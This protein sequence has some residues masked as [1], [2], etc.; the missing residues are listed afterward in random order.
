MSRRNR[1]PELAATTTDSGIEM[2]V[3]LGMSKHVA[4]NCHRR[5]RKELTRTVLAAKKEA[6]FFTV[7]NHF[8]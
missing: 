4:K 3:E 7:M 2:P 1:T 6:R 8:A 5:L